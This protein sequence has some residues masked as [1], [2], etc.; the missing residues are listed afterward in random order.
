MPKAL[1]NAQVMA[2]LDRYRQGERPWP[3]RGS[4][5]HVDFGDGDPVPLKYLYGLATGAEPSSLS[6]NQIKAAVEHLGLNIV[7]INAW[8][9]KINV[10]IKT[11]DSLEVG[12]IY[13]RSALKEQFGIKDATINNG[14]FK[15][16]GH[17]S[18]W[19]FVTEEKTPDRT[20]Y[21]DMLESDVLTME[22]QTAGRTDNLIIEHA[23]HG[24]EILLFYRNSKLQYPDAGFRYE[25]A[26]RYETH[27]GSGPTTFTLHRDKP[28]SQFKH[29][30]KRTWELALDAVA[31]L[32]GSGGRQEILAW[33]TKL[34]PDYNEKNIV[35]LLMLSVNSP[36]RTS[37]TQNIRSRRTDQGIEYDRLFK[38]GDGRGVT[39]ELYD[40]AHHGIWEIYPDQTSSN[41]HGM[42]VRRIVD[43]VMT[44]LADAVKDAEEIGAFDAKNVEDARKRVLA[45][46][47]R[48]RGQPAF[49]KA[50]IDAY[51]GACAI[52]GCDL[53]MILEAAHVHP[54]KG[55]HTNAISNGL[56]LRAD[57]HTLFDLR[58]IAIDPETLMVLVS[59][60]LDGTEYAG[61]RNRKLDPIKI[62]AQRISVSALTWHRSRC[63]W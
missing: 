47:V 22:G 12:N 26:F 55:E 29:G 11:S 54:Y 37:Y 4:I 7:D 36:A 28:A 41:R 60:E 52:T 18:V 33:I 43:P 30:N 1:T 56:L 15:P 25:G 5:W 39:F 8:R 38:V 61:L 50:L 20:Q 57:I 59:P 23:D 34:Y 48:R 42:G 27:S 35:D 44:A 14:I 6:T 62:A 9:V 13:T 45:G 17:R 63:D 51:G 49:R 3:E 31:A 24:D 2:G 40:P 46:I 21:Q 19:L 53:T 10:P 58:L 16:K 32:G